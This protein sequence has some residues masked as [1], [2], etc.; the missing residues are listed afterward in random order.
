LLLLI[1]GVPSIYYGQEIGMQGKIGNWGNTDGNDIPR[2]A[3]FDWYKSGQGKGMATWYKNTGGWW[4]NTDIKSNDGISA[5]EQLN[6][7]SSL[8]NY[9]KTLIQLKQSNPALANGNYANALNDNHEVFSFCRKYKNRKVLVAVNLSGAQQTAIFEEAYKRY[10]PMFGK[11]KVQNSS[12]H[13][14]PYEIAVFD[15]K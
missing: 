14:N 15:V 5:E 2:R 10:I 3:A 7:T 9:Y 6:D 13:L 11:S 8:L 1:G 12:V 4:D